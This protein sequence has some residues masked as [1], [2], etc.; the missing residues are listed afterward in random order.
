MTLI[1]IARNA[2]GAVESLRAQRHAGYAPAGEDIVCAAISALMQ[3]AAIAVERLGGFVE[4]R[5]QP[6]KAEAALTGTM[7]HGARAEGETVLAAIADG[8]RA[9]RESYPDYLSI[10]EV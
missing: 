2:S 7:S 3:T 5:E 9:I 4:I 8:L 1:T 10:R 6:A